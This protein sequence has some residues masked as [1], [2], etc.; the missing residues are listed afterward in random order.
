MQFIKLLKGHLIRMVIKNTYRTL[1]KN[2]HKTLHLGHQGVHLLLE[3]DLVD[4]LV[5]DNCDWHLWF[6]SGKCFIWIKSPDCTSTN[7]WRQFSTI[8]DSLFL[9]FCLKRFLLRKRP[10]RRE[11]GRAILQATSSNFSILLLEFCSSSGV[12][13]FW[14]WIWLQDIV[15]ICDLI[16]CYFEL[17]S[18]LS[19]F[20]VSYILWIY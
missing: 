4:L 13:G 2:I 14:L 10:Q 17:S 3:P 19:P 5:T 15:A 16:Q 1:Y 18:T 7:N 8:I 11:M 9:Y 12:T 20:W 6:P